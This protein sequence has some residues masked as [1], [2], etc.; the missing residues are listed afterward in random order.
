MLFGSKNAKVTYQKLVNKMF[1]ELIGKTMNVYVNDMLVKCL[2]AIDHVKHLAVAF[3]IIRS[4]R[5]RLIT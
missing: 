1:I 2:E 5:M 3:Q 4:N